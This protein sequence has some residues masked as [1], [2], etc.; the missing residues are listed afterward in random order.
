MSVTSRIVLSL[1]AL[2][3]ALVVGLSFAHSDRGTKHYFRFLHAARNEEYVE[4]I[5]EYHRLPFAI[6]KEPRVE[7]YY[8]EA[9]EHVGDSAKVDFMPTAEP[10]DIGAF[11]AFLLGCLVCY[12]VSR[13]RRQKCYSA[14]KVA[15]PEPPTEGQK[16]FIRRINNGLV[17]YGLT[18][19]SAAV[20][21]KTKLSS[22]S[23]AAKRQRI[24]INPFEFMSSS[25]F[26]REYMRIERERKRAQEKI[27][28]QQEM[29]KRRLEREAS[30]M[31]KAEERLYNKRIAEEEKLVKAREEGRT[32]IVRKARN[33][34]AKTIQELQNLVND[35]LADKVI[36]PQEVRQLKAW[37]LANQSSP[38]EFA[39]MLKL[40]D[41][42]LVDGIIDADETQAL[43]EGVIDCLVTL[44]ART[45]D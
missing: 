14:V 32:G 37:L 33:A 2:S 7:K 28:R 43:Y 8:Q 26:R 44:R 4:A 18:K 23:S 41:E 15:A 3:L 45:S 20:F 29:Q 12:F 31:Q 35:I 24:D 39:P 10:A 38:D 30:K 27:A 5:K 19:E 21:I 1:L 25:P 9:R 34:K 13:P 40:I 22:V 42:S 36:E 6:R 16:Q 17:P 11:G